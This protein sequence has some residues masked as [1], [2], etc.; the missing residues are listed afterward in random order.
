[1]FTASNGRSTL[2]QCARRYLGCES[3][4]D[5]TDSQGKPVRLSYDRWLNRSPSEIETV[6]LDYLAKDAEPRCLS[7][8]RISMEDFGPPSGRRRCGVFVIR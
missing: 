6:Y 3:P 7:H 2:E 1:M 4:K 8:G 5:T